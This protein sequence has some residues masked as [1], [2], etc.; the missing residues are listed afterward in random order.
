V[1]LKPEELRWQKLVPQLGDRSPEIVILHVH[2]ATRATTLMIRT[3][4]NFHVP[5][6]WHS[7]GEKHTVISGSFIFECNGR[8]VELKAGSF[9]YIPPR[10]IHQAWT[11]PNEDCVLF[12]DVEGP[13]DVNW[14]EPPPWVMA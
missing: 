12:T 5:R 2:P 14:V 1:F 6:H 7:H 3:P 4:R 8:C 10:V 13:W 11:P 9:N